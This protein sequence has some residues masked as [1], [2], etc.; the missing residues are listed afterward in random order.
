MTGR[1]NAAAKG[2]RYLTEGRLTVQQVSRAGV[3]AFARGVVQPMR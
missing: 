3:V 2:R 1:E